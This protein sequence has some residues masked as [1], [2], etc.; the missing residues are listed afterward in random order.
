MNESPSC[1]GPPGKFPLEIGKAPLGA[2]HSF[3]LLAQAGSASQV[4]QKELGR[5]L[6]CTLQPSGHQ[7]NGRHFIQQFDEELAMS[8]TVKHKNDMEKEELSGPPAVTSGFG[9]D[10]WKNFLIER[11]F[12]HLPEEGGEEE[13]IF[14]ELQERRIINFDETDLSLDR[15][16]GKGCGWKPTV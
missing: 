1:P 2:H 15:A 12:A 5:K 13:A 3:A 14:F 7:I 4:T 6:E 16:D 11:G 9:F 10:M 8:L